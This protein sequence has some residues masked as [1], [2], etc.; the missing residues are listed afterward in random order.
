[1]HDFDGTL[2]CGNLKNQ[3]TTVVLLCKRIQA[4]WQSSHHGRL[5][6]ES[7]SHKTKQESFDDDTGSYLSLGKR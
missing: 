3:S 6:V 5:V 4:Y 7:I 1:M 2:S